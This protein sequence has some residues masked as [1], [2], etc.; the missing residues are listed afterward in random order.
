MKLLPRPKYNMI[1]EL[2][3][4]YEIAKEL[5]EPFEKAIEE[6]V[7]FFD[8]PIYKEF[9]QLFYFERH[10]FIN[11]FP[12]SRSMM[13]YLKDKLYI[14]ETQ[15]YTIRKEIVYKSAMIFYKYNIIED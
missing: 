8:V 5:D 2:L 6:I 11:R 4:T 10:K 12:D 7:K 3:R 13:N 14:S 9:L 15:V 1:E